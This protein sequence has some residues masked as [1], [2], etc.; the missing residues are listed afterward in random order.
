MGAE[1]LAVGF[2]DLRGFSRY[3]AKRGDEA[4][5]RVA[6]AFTHL[7]E[8]Q[9]ARNGG[10]L[11]KTYGDGVMTSFDD[12]GRAVACSAGMQ[13][14][15][16]TYN[17]AREDDAICA[18]IGLTWG[19]AIR[20]GDDLFGHSVNLAK[21][22]ADVAKGC[23]IVV[24]ESIVDQ[25]RHRPDLA[26]RDLGERD[27]KGVGPHRLYEF[28]WR[29]EVDK[30]SLPDDSLDLVLTE[31]HKLVLEFAKPLEETL[32]SI[33]EKLEP[34]DGEAG[35]I[36]GLKRKMAERLV[37][38]FPKWLGALQKYGG[39]LEHRLEE[40]EATVE[41]GHLCVRLPE[42]RVLSFTG[43]QIDRGAAERFVARLAALRQEKTGASDSAG[44]G[45]EAD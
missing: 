33:R 23:Q 41:G 26:F 5:L 3:T 1:P 16:S 40:I 36:A 44:P 2:S 18:G 37:R 38:D 39:G 14:A 28:L 21:R 13:E 4:A 31:D 9:V 15:L 11:L 24:D 17:E 19:P 6:Q 8:E 20:T 22:L 30:L 7:V 27:L 45:R 29:N 10:R 25:T 32:R 34:R 43:R 35:A 12:P 42:G